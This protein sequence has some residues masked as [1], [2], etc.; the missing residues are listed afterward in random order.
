MERWSEN[1][2]K[3]GGYR[4]KLMEGDLCKGMRVNG[5]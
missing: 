3:R 4:E 1:I 2:G 5:R